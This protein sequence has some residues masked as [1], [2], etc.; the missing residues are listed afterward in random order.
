MATKLGIEDY[1]SVVLRNE[2][3]YQA[4]KESL[5]KD[6][7]KVEIYYRS[8]NLQVIQEQPKY[9]VRELDKMGSLQIFKADTKR[10]SIVT[11]S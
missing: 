4:T 3:E 5:Q 10:F 8:L 2:T 6:M 11:S 9:D 7:L 1:L